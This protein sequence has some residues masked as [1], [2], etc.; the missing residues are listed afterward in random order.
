SKSKFSPELISRLMAS[1]SFGYGLFQLCTSLLPPSLL[2]LVHVL[3]L[4]GDRHSGLAA[5][6]FTRNSNDMRA[7]LA[8]LALL[9]YH[10]VVRPFF[11]LDGAHIRAGVEASLLLLKE[12]DMNYSNSALFLFFRG[13]TLRL[14]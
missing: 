12:N 11:A 10:T 1:V 14:Q 7:P 8:T 2:R 3:G 9:W 6:M 4:Q 13:R 5:L